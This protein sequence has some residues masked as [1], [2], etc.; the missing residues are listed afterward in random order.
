MHKKLQELFST[1]PID[2]SQIPQEDMDKEI[3]R[4]AIV[5]EYDA[6][7]AYEQMV[8]MTDDE[9]IIKLFEHVISEEKRH[10]AELQEI[11]KEID[12]EQA[13]F[14]SADNITPEESMKSKALKVLEELILTEGKEYLYLIDLDERGSF[15]AH[16][17]DAKTGKIVFEFSNE[18][19]VI[20]DEGNPTGE[21]EQGEIGMVRD[22]YMK[23]AKD[24]VGLEEYLIDMKIIPAGSQLK[25]G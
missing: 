2:L 23:H 4:A 3:L 24:I 16:V 7:N 25:K 10:V 9:V 21:M 13:D 17:E 14:M 8:N 22:G 18:E 19:E 6:I 5:A 15:R 20:D 11:L 12:S 1:V